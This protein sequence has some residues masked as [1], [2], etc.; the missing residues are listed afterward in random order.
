MGS[1]PVAQGVRL[2]SPVAWTDQGMGLGVLGLQ[3][4]A[5]PAGNAAG[6]EAKE[7]GTGLHGIAQARQVLGET[8]WA[9][10]TAAPPRLLHRMDREGDV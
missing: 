9:A 7:S 2:H 10:G 8:A 3:T 4:W 6:P 5:R 1:G